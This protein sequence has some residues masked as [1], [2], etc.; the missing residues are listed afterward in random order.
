VIEA[1]R[2]HLSDLAAQG[3]VKPLV[4]ERLALAD[5]ADAVQRLAD[6]ATVGRVAYV[7]AESAR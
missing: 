5:V 4:S 7:A 1:A 3:A 6:G 2:E